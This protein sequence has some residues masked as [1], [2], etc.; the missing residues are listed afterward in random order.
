MPSIFASPIIKYSNCVHCFFFPLKIQTVI[1]ASFLIQLLLVSHNSNRFHR[2]FLFSS[3]RPCISPSSSHL[4]SS[5]S[6]INDAEL[7]NNNSRFSLTSTSTLLL[8]SLNYF[9]YPQKWHQ[10][11]T[12]SINNLKEM[13]VETSSSSSSE[14]REPCPAQSYATHRNLSRSRGMNWRRRCSLFVLVD[15]S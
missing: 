12:K 4:C 10:H 2:I 14:W 13:I 7:F 3:A 1:N 8:F 11:S 6:K 9:Y 5:F 15:V